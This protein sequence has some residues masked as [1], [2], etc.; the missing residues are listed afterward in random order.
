MAAPYETDDRGAVDGFA[1]L[2]SD[3]AVLQDLIR[4]VRYAGP[5]RA[6]EQERLLEQAGLGDQGS[7]D[8]LVAVHLPMVVRLAAAMGKQVLSPSDLVQE[9]SIGLVEA[10]RS[11]SKS[12]QPEFMSFAEQK[13]GAQMDAAIVAESAV[14]RDSESL[15]AAAADYEQTESVL[16]RELH[17]QPTPAELA[18]KLEWTVD[19]TAYVAQVVVEARRRHDEEMLAFVDPADIDFDDDERAEFDG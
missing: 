14:L 11:F 12:R 19:R 5:L 7:Q 1:P 18:E 3:A 17:R 9:G 16:R 15:I 2:D 13:I 10:I 4:Q 6:G 8:R